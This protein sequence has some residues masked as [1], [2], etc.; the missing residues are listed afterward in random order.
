MT[1]VT[2]RYMDD[3]ISVIELPS[4]EEEYTIRAGDDGDYFIIEDTNENAVG[5]IVCNNVKYV[6][7]GEIID[8]FQNIKS[9]KQEEN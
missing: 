2:I 3:S 1:K 8:N 6:V 9:V 4:G 5:W 7:L